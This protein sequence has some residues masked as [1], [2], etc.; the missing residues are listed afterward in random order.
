MK[1]QF[2]YS[3]FSNAQEAEQ[4]IEIASQ[5]FGGSSDDVQSY[6][7]LIG[8]ENFRVIHRSRRAIGGLAIYHM[9]QWF[10]GQSVPM[11]GIAAV[12]IAPEYRGSKQLLAATLSE[13]LSVALQL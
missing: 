7:D 3:T 6:L 1:S 9:G 13:E 12:G 8:R 10:G 4:F 2:E 5:C 11:A